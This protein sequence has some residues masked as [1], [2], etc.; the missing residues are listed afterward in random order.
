MS[1]IAPEYVAARRVLLDALVALEGHLDSLVL[2]GAQAVYHHTGASELNVPLMTTNAD[3]AVNTRGAL[4]VFRL[5]QAVER[6]EFLD[7]FAKH[8]EDEHAAAVTL[9]A[10]EVL[11][12]HGTAP[13]AKLA[14]LAETASQGDRTVAPTFAALV[15]ELL[16]GQ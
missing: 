3:L 13:E 1:E 14:Q 16:A 12:A 11:R 2:V 6:D 5:L 4:D 9:E 15:K 8:R 10:L 7:G